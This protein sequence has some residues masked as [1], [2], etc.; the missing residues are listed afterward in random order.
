MK[1][2]IL[3]A[4]CC[5]LSFAPAL[6]PAADSA[7]EEYPEGRLSEDKQIALLLEASVHTCAQLKALQTHLATFRL[8]ETACIQSPSNGEALYKLS[9]CAFKLVTDIRETHVEPYF[10]SAFLEE[11]ERISKPAKNRAI[12][13]IC[14]Q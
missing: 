6:L 7:E 13:P 11:L 4:A 5:V 8:Q 14:P 3:S 1:R 2:I 12:P 9:E 10:R